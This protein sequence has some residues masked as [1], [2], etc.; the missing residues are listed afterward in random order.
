MRFISLLTLCLIFSFSCFAQDEYSAIDPMV[1]AKIQALGQKNADIMVCYYEPCY[2]SFM[3]SSRDSCTAFS[4]KYVL[5]GVKKKCFIQRFDNCRSY[6]PVEMNPRL[7]SFIQNN[8]SNIKT[9]KLK[10]MAYKTKGNVKDSIQEI[11]VEDHSCH[12]IFEVHWGKQR[13]TIDI[14]DFPLEASY[15]SAHPNLNFAENQMNIL[16]E[17]RNVAVKEVQYYLKPN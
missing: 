8:Y 17:L 5:W 13:D 12:Y 6:S 11:Y 16:N 3:R 10:N 14:D 9:A 1:D 7:L 15:D 2:G 4:I